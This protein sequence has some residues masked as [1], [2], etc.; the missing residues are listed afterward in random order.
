MDWTNIHKLFGASFRGAVGILYLLR[1]ERL[2]ASGCPRT[3]NRPNWRGS[4]GAGGT[5]SPLACGAGARS[6]VSTGQVRTDGCDCLVDGGSEVAAKLLPR[7]RRGHTS[8]AEAPLFWRGERGP[9]LKPWRTQRQGQR[10]QQRQE[11]RRNT[12]V[13]P[14][15]RAMRLHGFGRDDVRWEW[16]VSAEMTCVGSSNRGSLRFAAG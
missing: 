10:Q 1:C 13:S 5:P 16:C 8:E 3:L 9:R 12:G 11:Q 2:P 14:L 6:V 4:R 7:G 15:R